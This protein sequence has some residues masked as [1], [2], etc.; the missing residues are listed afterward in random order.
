MK[1]LPSSG[2]L[3]VPNDFN[4]SAVER[5]REIMASY[6]TS[7]A[8]P[9][10]SFAAAW[11]GLSYRFRSADEYHRDFTVAMQA[12]DAPPSEE[13]YQQERALFSFFSAGLSTLECFCFAT[14]CLGSIARP[15][16]FPMTKD[17][18]LRFYPADVAKTFATEFPRERI[19]NLLQQ[20]VTAPE[21]A[22]LA[23][24]RNVLSHRGTL[25]RSV[26]VSV[27]TGSSGKTGAYIPSNPKSLSSNWE[28]DQTVNVNLTFAFRK[29]L[30]K[31]VDDLL[32]SASEFVRTHLDKVP[33][34][35]SNTP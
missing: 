3:L 32:E 2:G 28:F 16:A 29:W 22:H 27:G 4:G 9:W 17:R 23:D 19:T 30:A 6:S 35:S 21:F 5:V 26:Q 13:R 24:L 34:A 25:P 10:R 14:Y 31:T 7:D 15:T 20:L 1:E 33:A 18:D 11:N 12:G 8:G